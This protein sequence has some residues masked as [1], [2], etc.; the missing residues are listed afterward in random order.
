MKYSFLIYFFGRMEQI[1]D[2][3]EFVW[4]KVLNLKS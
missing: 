2:S 1:H 3:L 4:Y